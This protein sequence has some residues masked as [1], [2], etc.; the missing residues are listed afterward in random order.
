MEYKII[1]KS[2]FTLTEDV[3]FSRKLKS[4]DK[5]AF[6]DLVA[7]YAEK[8]I[9]TCYRFFPIREDAE[10]ISQE[11]FIEVLKSIKS[12]RCDS[13]LSTWIYRITVSKCLDELKKRKRK[14]RFMAIG[15]VLHL[16]E[17]ANLLGG[18]TK[19]DKYIQ[20]QD[21]MK[22]VMRALNTLPDN[23]RVAFTL[24]KVEGYTNK[25]IA[26][27]LNTTIVAVESLISHAKKKVKDELKTILKK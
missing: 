2:N 9:N 14:K 23:Q 6:N 8:V 17:V 7:L 13:K 22:E 4:G 5:A 12:F 16:D 19:P 18:G 15:K 1:D 20:E 25:E 10:D 3:D 24:S 21:K 27:I 26:E 11:V